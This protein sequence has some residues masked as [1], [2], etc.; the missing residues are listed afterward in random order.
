MSRMN[1]YTHDKFGWMILISATMAGTTFLLLVVPYIIFYVT[2]NMRTPQS[3]FFCFRRYAPVLQCVDAF[4][5]DFSWIMI[6]FDGWIKAFQR[7]L[8]TGILVALVISSDLRMAFRKRL[9]FCGKFP[10]NKRSKISAPEAGRRRLSSSVVVTSVLWFFWNQ[11]YIYIWYRVWLN[12]VAKFFIDYLYI[13]SF[14]KSKY[15]VY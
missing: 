8:R 12:Y 13:F 2:R 11:N 9:F 1:R 15:S 7:F 4:L 6:K 3:I 14:L 10:E 5:G